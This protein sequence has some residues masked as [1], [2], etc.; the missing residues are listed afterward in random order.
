[1]LV[2]EWVWSASQTYLTLLC[3]K[4]GA[5][6]PARTGSR[7]VSFCLNAIKPGNEARSRVHLSEPQVGGQIQKS[8][9]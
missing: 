5:R 8:K 3:M 1:M 7:I 6:R 2:S 9:C 4:F